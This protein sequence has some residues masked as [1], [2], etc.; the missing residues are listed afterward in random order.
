MTQANL[1]K[2]KVRIDETN[3]ESEKVRKLGVAGRSE[4]NKTIQ[5]L[6][7]HSLRPNWWK[8]EPTVGSRWCQFA[9]NLGVAYWVNAYANSM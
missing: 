5:D 2:L 7:L 8:M 6:M 3:D 9:F 1:K 4:P